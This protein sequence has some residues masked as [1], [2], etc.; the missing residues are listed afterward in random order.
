MSPR[1]PFEKT[2]VGRH[3]AES[4]VWRV[5]GSAAAVRATAV[6]K[7]RLNTDLQNQIKNIFIKTKQQHNNHTHR[8][9]PIINKL[10]RFPPMALSPFKQIC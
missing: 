2:G 3:E 5:K 10:T 1:L 6:Y 7:A 4:R 8:N 9:P